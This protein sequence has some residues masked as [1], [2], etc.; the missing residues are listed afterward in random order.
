MWSAMADFRL[1]GKI[2]SQSSFVFRPGVAIHIIEVVVSYESTYHDV[3][4]MTP[5]IRTYIIYA[6]PSVHINNS[7]MSKLII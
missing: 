3:T 7:K 2:D 5:Y 1:Y 4:S 6:I